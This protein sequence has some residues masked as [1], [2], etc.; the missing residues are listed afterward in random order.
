[1]LLEGLCLPIFIMSLIATENIEKESQIT[2]RG[3][4]QS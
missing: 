1:M 3:V 4:E 2:G